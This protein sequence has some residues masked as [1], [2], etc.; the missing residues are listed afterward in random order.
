MKKSLIA[1]A[2]TGAFAA[3][4]FAQ[5]A[6]P[7]SAHTFSANVAVVSDYAFRGV[8]QNDERMAL[9]GGFD[10]AHASGF[11]AGFW[12]SNVSW[13][14]DSSADV[15]NSIET[16]LYAGYSGT[17][18]PIGYDVGLL[19][20]YYPGKYGAVY[21]AGA[22]KPHTLEGY[23]G[24]SWEFLSFKY[25]YAFSDLF[26]LPKS[27]G[28]QYYDLGLNY[29]LGSGFTIDAH[30]GYNDIKVNKA[31]YTDWKIGVSKEYEGFT[32]GLHYVDSD[33][34][35]SKLADDRYIL[36]VSKSF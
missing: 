4:A 21:R 35:N 17:A 32:F 33:I 16:N 20:Y 11:Y 6:A 3:P 8:S 13:L 23:I 24:L 18:G 34:K 9:Q 14:S 36:S 31:S 25:S 27:D 22:E 30:V 29:D 15:S 26:G 28:S 7:E 19:Q 12:A 5:Q 1:L 10:Y 2:L